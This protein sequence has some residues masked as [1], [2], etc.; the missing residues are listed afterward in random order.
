MR[1]FAFA[2][3]VLLL[4][5]ALPA[6]AGPTPPAGGP[7]EIGPWWASG[8]VGGT[9]TQNQEGIEIVWTG[10]IFAEFEFS[11]VDSGEATGVWDFSG[12]AG[13]ELQGLVEELD[14]E[15]FADVAYSGGG[16]ISGTNAELVLDGTVDTAGTVVATTPGGEVERSISNTNQ[17]STLRMAIRAALCDE[18]YGDWALPVQ[19]AF[20][21]AGFE[22]SIDGFWIG[23]R[24]TE[25]MVAETDRL[26]EAAGF[27]G[28]NAPPLESR[29]EVL[30][31]SAVL[32][33]D[34][35][36]FVERFPNWTMEEIFELLER[37]EALLNEIR[38]LSECDRRLYGEDNIEDFIS[39]LTF[40]IQDL[41]RIGATAEDL[42]SA[43]W[44][45]LVQ[46]ASRTGVVGPGAV[47]PAEALEAEQSLI[48]EGEEI[49]EAN[50]DPDDGLV[51]VN[52]D[53]KRVMATG[54][55][56]NWT[57]FVNNVE[58]HARATYGAFLAGE[59][60]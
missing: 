25:G 41:I 23:F 14:V 38:N 15:A 12:N 32:L 50:V 34:Y 48:D 49:L 30:G 52:D 9:A 55:T 1:R 28:P 6:V 18:A 60:P 39:G 36:N 21:G 4:A 47:N 19:A 54:A 42:S 56:M 5:V 10:Q 46:L 35:N 2:I 44:Q 24:E 51:L 57:Y 59:E 43:T 11:V 7:L 20:E 37:S 13:V 17:I 16:Q 27:T 58:H 29:S 33:S 40:V 22:A 8:M 3:G 31:L 26:L 45:Q 53:T